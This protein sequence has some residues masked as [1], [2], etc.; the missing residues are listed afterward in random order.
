MLLA[1]LE[2]ENTSSIGLSVTQGK[3]LRPEREETFA[4]TQACPQ[5]MVL[6][7]APLTLVEAQRKIIFIQTER[8]REAMPASI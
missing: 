3:G 8:W 5:L 4:Q 1:K 6:Q 7:G 2:L